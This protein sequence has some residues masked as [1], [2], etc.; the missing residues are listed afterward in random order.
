[1]VVV[2]V[3]EKKKDSLKKQS[4]KSRSFQNRTDPSPA[5]GITPKGFEAVVRNNLVGTWTMT[6]EV[7]HQ[8]FSKTRKG[9]IVNITACVK[10]GF[11]GMMH[12]GAARAGGK[13]KKK[14]KNYKQT[15]SF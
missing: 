10:R 1:M 9:R 12:T 2:N 8:V 13:R 14:N 15:T 4:L 3:R 6:Y 11:P 7:F 5:A